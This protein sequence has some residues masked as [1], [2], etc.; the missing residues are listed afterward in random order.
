MFR[1]KEVSTKLTLYTLS[2][3]LELRIWV[4]SYQLGKGEFF[5]VESLI[6]PNMMKDVTVEC[7][8]PEAK[9]LAMKS[10]EFSNFLPHQVL[11]RTKKSELAKSQFRV[12]MF[13]HKFRKLVRNLQEGKDLEI[14]NEQEV[15]E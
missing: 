7:F 14:E 4:D 9:V 2:K 12:N 1:A 3:F 11:E 13:T 15:I 10:D 8:S 6:D 5:G